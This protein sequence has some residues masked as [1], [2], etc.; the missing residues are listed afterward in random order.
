M[1]VSSDNTVI[2]VISEGK[3]VQVR[4]QKVNSIIR[5]IRLYSM[6]PLGF[7]NLGHQIVVFG[8]QGKQSAIL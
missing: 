2:A 8:K 7:T 5:E 3:R 4:K 6:L 1:S